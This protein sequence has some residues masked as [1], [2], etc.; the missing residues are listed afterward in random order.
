MYRY[1]VLIQAFVL[2]VHSFIQCAVCVCER[3]RTL[4]RYLKRR[5]RS[6]HMTCDQ[7]YHLPRRTVSCSQQYEA[8]LA[9]V[10]AE[11]SPTHKIDWS[12][13]QSE[14][15]LTAITYSTLER[16]HDCNRTLL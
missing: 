9:I 7:C 14:R 11:K 15:V 10:N 8:V 2:A 1:N 5:I 12:D 4:T 6:L 13:R 16:S 3:N